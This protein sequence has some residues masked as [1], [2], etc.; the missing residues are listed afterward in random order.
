MR[1]F[2]LAPGNHRRPLHTAVRTGARTLALGRIEGRPARKLNP[3]ILRV[4]IRTL[5]RALNPRNEIEVA[6]KR[7]LR[8]ELVAPQVRGGIAHARALRPEFVTSCAGQ[9]ACPG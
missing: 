4:P 1:M 3:T 9:G 8:G 7:R 5:E 2:P 6:I